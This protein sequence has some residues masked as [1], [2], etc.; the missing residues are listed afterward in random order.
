M[1]RELRKTAKAQRRHGLVLANG[2]LLTYQHV[3]CLSNHPRRDSSP[4]PENNPLPDV[5][6][7]LAVIPV[8]NRAEGKAIVEVKWV[9][10]W[11]YCYADYIADVHGRVQSG[12]Q[13]FTRACRWATKEY[14]A[15]F[16]G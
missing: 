11:Q 1:V 6:S 16:P 10:Q 14:W 8:A 12:W 3:V 5:L 15:S 9:I 7:D 4:Y 2:G 13:S